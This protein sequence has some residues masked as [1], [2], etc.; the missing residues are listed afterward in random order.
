[1]KK[2][3]DADFSIASLE[4][5]RGAWDNITKHAEDILRGHFHDKSSCDIKI[6]DIASGPGEPALTLANKFPEAIVYSVDINPK[7]VEV[8]EERSKSLGVTNV[9]ALV[10]NM[11]DLVDFNDGMFDLVTSSFGLM[12]CEDPDLALS[13]VHRVLKPGGTA[14]ITA[15]E[16]LSTERASK[17]LLQAASRSDWLPER[18]LDPMAFAKPLLLETAI[19]K[20]YMSLVKVDH[21]EYPIRISGL[22][23]APEDYSFCLVSEHIYPNLVE[24]EESCDCPDAIKDAKSVFDSIVA[25]SNWILRDDDGHMLTVPNRYKLAVARRG[26][27]KS[28]GKEKMLLRNKKNLNLHPRAVG[29][30]PST[31][32]EVSQA[33]DSI[34]ANAFSQINHGPWQHVVSAVENTIKGHDMSSIRILDLASGLGEPACSLAKRFPLTSVVATDISPIAVESIKKNIQ[35]LGLRNMRALVEDAQNL[36]KFQPGAFDVVTCSFGLS[37]LPDPEKAIEEVHRILK[38][39]GSFIATVWDSISIEHISDEIMEEVMKGEPAPP[40]ILDLLSFAEPRKLEELIENSGMSIINVD[41]DEVSFLL[42]G[43][44]HNSDEVAFNLVTIPIHHSLVQIE[45]CGKN[46][47]AFEDAHLAFKKIVDAKEL[48]YTDMQDRIWTGPNRFKLVLARRQYEDSDKSPQERTKA[49]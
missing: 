22:E 1:M 32:E 48:V 15:W 18:I 10:G 28:N 31:S 43:L 9:K 3:F 40:R 14:I 21:G 11:E 4:T 30:K 37:F 34:L 5:N 20:N 35:A 13:E 6:L 46:Q 39:G 41:H 7:M 45:E 42:S 33:F 17:E 26:Y 2:A 38:P 19:E 16:N 27:E 44:G 36:S 23:D 24:L 12:Y 47:H 29:P 8:A 25:N 49:S